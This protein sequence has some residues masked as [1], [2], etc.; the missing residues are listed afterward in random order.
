MS[1]MIPSFVTGA[2]SKVCIGPNTVAYAQDTSYNVTVSTIP[3]ETMGRYEVVSN[4]PIAYFVDGTLSIIRYT[5]GSQTLLSTAQKALD[6]TNPAGNGVGT[7][8]TGTV[9]AADMFDP[10]NLPASQ[11]FDLVIYRKGQNPANPEMFITIHDCRFTRKGAALTKRGIWVE[12][13]AFNAI[14]L[15]D[16]SMTA[17]T[18]GDQDQT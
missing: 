2:N 7:I 9:T 1:G 6:K 5:K 17:N 13:F 12:Q 15:D 11:T 16:D 14:L 4:E 8:P 3:I 10:A 18:S